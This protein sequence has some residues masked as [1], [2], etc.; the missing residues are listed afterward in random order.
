[1][2]KFDD[3]NYNYALAQESTDFLDDRNIQMHQWKVVFIVDIDI[4]SETYIQETHKMISKNEPLAVYIY[5][6]PIDK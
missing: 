5:P 2:F 6:N 3:H 1:M 4:Y